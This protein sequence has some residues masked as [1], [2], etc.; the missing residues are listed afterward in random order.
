MVIDNKR[1]DNACAN[2]CLPAYKVLTIAKVSTCVLSRIRHGK[3][4]RAV[5]V[6]RIAKALGVKPEEITV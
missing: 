3:D 2:S 5:T 6:G 1:F 4:L